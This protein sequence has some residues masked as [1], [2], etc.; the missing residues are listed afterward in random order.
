MTRVLTLTYSSSDDDD[1][2]FFSFC[3][4]LGSIGTFLEG[5]VIAWIVANY[6]WPAMFASMI[7]LSVFGAFTSFRAARIYRSIKTLSS[8]SLN[9]VVA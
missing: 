2:F 9:Q 7:F 3:L 6:G 8:S 5:P 1:V 4:G